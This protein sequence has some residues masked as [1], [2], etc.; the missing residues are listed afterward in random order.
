MDYTRYTKG[1]YTIGKLT[2]FNDG[3][4]IAFFLTPEGQSLVRDTFVEH[5]K[6]AK[7]GDNDGGGVDTTYDGEQAFQRLSDLVQFKMKKAVEVVVEEAEEE[8]K[9]QVQQINERR[10][11]VHAAGTVAEIAAKYG[12]SKSEV[13]KMKREGTLDAA[14]AQ[15]EN[16]DE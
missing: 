8:H 3:E 11:S 9:S 4:T 1:L 13:R 10:N 14:L 15:S 5:A 7:E 6:R 2:E 12:L 16:Q